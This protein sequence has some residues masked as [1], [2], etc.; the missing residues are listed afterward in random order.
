V[1]VE[2]TTSQ[3][4]IYFGH[5]LNLR[6]DTV[7]LANGGVARREIVEHRDAVTIVPLDADGNVLFVRQFRKPAEQELYELPAGVMDEGESPEQAAQRELSEE[8]GFRAG[9]LKHLA[10][11]YSSAGFCTEYMHIFAATDHSP[12]QGT[13]DEDEDITL[14]RIPLADAL[15]MIATGELRDAKTLIG[16]LLV[17]R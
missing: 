11:C 7:R 12:K 14:H 10:G 13:P 3:E 9:T 4:Y 5:I 2:T 15:G 1:G 6:V 17:S 8:T 16:L